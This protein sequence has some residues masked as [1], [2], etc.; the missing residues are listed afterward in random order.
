MS[1]GEKNKGYAVKG[2]RPA[3]SAGRRAQGTGRRAQAN[4]EDYAVFYISLI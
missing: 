4:I 1:E 2:L 3:K